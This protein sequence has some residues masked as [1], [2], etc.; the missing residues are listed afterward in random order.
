MVKGSNAE[1]QKSLFQIETIDSMINNLHD[2]ASDVPIK[3]VRFEILLFS[4]DNI[5]PEKY[6][7]YEFEIASNSNLK[8][9]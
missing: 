1:S 8:E 3:G 4:K 9:S 6:S 2:V 5:P 7:S